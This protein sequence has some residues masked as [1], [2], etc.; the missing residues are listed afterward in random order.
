MFDLSS[1]QIK[2][3]ERIKLLILDVDG[4]LTDGRL[5][6]DNVGNEYKCFHARD[7]HGLKLLQQTG[8]EIAVISG[9]SS[10]SVLLRMQSLGITHVYQGYED[11]RSA[12][13]DVLKNL[14]LSPEQVAYAGDDLLD[15]PIMT[16]VGFAIAVKDA[17]FMVKKYADWH[18]TEQGGLGAV[19]EVCD[20]IMSVQGNL[21]TILASYLK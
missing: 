11:K 5:Y 17:N 3:I 9:R 10:N 19:R 7:G 21:D 18:T 8:V 20:V 6:F 2:K 13:A 12:F 1:E 4:V 15:L 14:Q 16:R